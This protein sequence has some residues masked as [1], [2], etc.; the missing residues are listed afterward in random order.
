MKT[1]CRVSLLA[2]ILAA[3]TVNGAAQTPGQTGQGLQITHG[4]VIERADGSSATI[5]WS[6]SQPSSSRIWYGTDKNNPTQ[7]AESSYSSGDTHRVEIKNLQPNT[8]YYFRL[9]SQ[10]GTAEAQG[11]GVMSFHTPA[12][13]HAPLTNQKAEVAEKESFETGRVKITAGPTLEE[14]TANSATV[15]WSTNLKGSA[16]VTYGTD[17]NNLTQ[18]AEAPWG[19][20]GLTHRVELRNLQPNTTYYF[21]VETGQAQGTQGAEVESPKAL[22]FKTTA[23]GAAPLRNER[24]H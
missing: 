18:F 8:T 23:A 7:M 20:G 9:E 4:P 12:S 10:R 15:A 6:T 3:L 16:R 19:A 22:S 24:P 1:L 2:G 17:P 13:G 11:P 14:V 21:R 5:A